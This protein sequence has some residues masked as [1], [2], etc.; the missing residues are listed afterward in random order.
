MDWLHSGVIVAMFAA[1]IFLL[2]A[3]YVR[4]KLQPNPLVNLSFLNSRNI[5]ILAISIF[6]FKF[7]HLASI[8]LV[9]SFLGNIQ[10]YRATETGHALAWD[11]VRQF[12]VV[13]L[14]ASAVIFTNSRL[15][16]AAGPSIVAP[17]APVFA[18]PRCP[19]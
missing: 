1:G 2:A 15:I 13:W 5:I 19:L 3:T 18:P 8:I 7:V 4:R 11:A 6:V 16:L 10:R 12:A 9:P 14:V 17:A